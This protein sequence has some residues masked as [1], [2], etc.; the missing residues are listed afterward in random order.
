MVREGGL[1]MFRVPWT[2]SLPPHS[3]SLSAL[4]V[5]NQGVICVGASIVPN[6]A[7]V[8][9]QA[10]HFSIYNIPPLI[11]LAI[12]QRRPSSPPRFYPILMASNYLLTLKAMVFVVT[13]ANLIVRRGGGVHAFVSIAAPSRR[14]RLP[15]FSCAVGR[16]THTFNASP[17]YANNQYLFPPSATRRLKQQSGDNNNNEIEPTWT[18]VPYQP[19]PSP[20][21]RKPARRSFSTSSSSSWTVPNQI[22]I[23]E[24]QLQIS[25]ARASGAGGQ[26]VNKVN[27]KVELRFHLNSASWIPAEVRDRIK[28]NESNRINNEG[29]LVVT[30]QEHR[31]QLKNRKDALNKLEEMIRNS[32]ARPKVRKMRKGLSKEAKVNRRE[33]KKRIS[34][35]KESRK[36]VDF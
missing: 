14:R 7:G 11:S 6:L 19:P 28:T 31:T 1:L 25:F 20:T 29:Y 35:K 4:L 23:P 8:R 18:Y 12:Q 27:T 22:N 26:N 2:T 30:S 5:S 21:I 9:S 33:D 16:Q 15:N 32:W 13:A 10:S 3:M 34:K 36:R 17:P 24:D